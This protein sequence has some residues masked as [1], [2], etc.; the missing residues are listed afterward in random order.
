MQ[1]KSILVIDN[2]LRTAEIISD[3]LKR[4]GA[5][6]V[7]VPDEASIYRELD[8]CCFNAILIDYTMSPKTGIQI[9][10]ELKSRPGFKPFMILMTAVVDDEVKKKAKNAGAGLVLWKPFGSKEL[11]K[12]L[13][14][15]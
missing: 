4:L 15:I 13:E 6:A 14:I 2:E 10:E 1:E 3:L 12:V 7:V 9:I 5:K 8:G 11:V